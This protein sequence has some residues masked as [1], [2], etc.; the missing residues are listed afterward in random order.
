MSDLYLE[1]LD[2]LVDEIRWLNKLIKQLKKEEQKERIKQ[3]RSKSLS[4]RK[5]KKV[6]WRI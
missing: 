4:Y 6:Y 2:S 1:H 5:K 3:R